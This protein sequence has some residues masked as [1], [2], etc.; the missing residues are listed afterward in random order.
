MPFTGVYVTRLVVN[1]REWPSVTNIG[2]RP[3]FPGAGAAV[4][5]HVLD[6]DGD[7]YDQSVALRFVQRLRDEKR[8]AQV[9]SLKKQ[10]AADVSQARQILQT[11]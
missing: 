10:I 9:S 7:L 8:F 11:G 5:C 3:T 2:S 4:E 6:F 1:D